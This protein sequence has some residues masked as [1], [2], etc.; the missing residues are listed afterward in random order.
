MYKKIVMVAALCF[1]L[2]ITAVIPVFSQS[3]DCSA[4]RHKDTAVSTVPAT[5]TTDGRVTYR[6]ELCG[7]T[8][9]AVIFATD[10]IWSGWTTSKKPTCTE[11]GTRYRTCS[12][13]GKHTETE[14]IKATGHEYT[15]SIIQK[16]SC[17]ESGIKKFECLKCGHTY[18]QKYGVPASHKYVE[19]ITTE[20]SCKANGILSYLCKT[21]GDVEKTEIISAK[22]HTF[23]AWIVDK[24]AAEGKSGLQH[25]ICEKCGFS[26][27]KTLTAL[28]L[29]NIQMPKSKPTAPESESEIPLITPVRVAVVGSNLGILW[30]FGFLI[31]SD[32]RLLAWD[33][34]KKKEYDEKRILEEA[35]ED[36]YGFV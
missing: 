6:C 25:R 23:G 13:D 12:R 34:K 32:I 1:A 30:I 24:A 18:T 20:P 19:K 17:T 2:F 8:F 28:P 31:L 9:T 3:Y 29:S 14:L 11:N 10:H 21:C 15:E 7:R 36:G 35:E 5:G 16:P 4:G 27:E 33:R 22:G 26:E